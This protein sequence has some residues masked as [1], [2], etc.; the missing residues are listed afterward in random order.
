MQQGKSVQVGTNGPISYGIAVAINNAA[1]STAAGESFDQL[2]QTNVDA[3]YN[4]GNLHTEAD[5]VTQFLDNGV[6]DS[7]FTAG[8]TNAPAADIPYGQTAPLVLFSTGVLGGTINVTAADVPE[9]IAASLL[10][11]GEMLLLRRRRNPAVV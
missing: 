7:A 6:A 8:I 1:Y 4:D 5:L 9:P 3:A 11:F 10:A 2:F